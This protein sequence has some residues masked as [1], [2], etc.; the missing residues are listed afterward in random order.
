MI[1]LRK[2]TENK[3]F[4]YCVKP[5]DDVG[6]VLKKSKNLKTYVR[7]P[8]LF[9]N[10]DLTVRQL[11]LKRKIITDFHDRKAKGENI[12]LK[13]SNGMPQIVVAKNL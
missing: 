5:E 4:E 6:L 2:H 9:V 12:Y 10:K 13:Y 8:K 7:N 3:T 1:R 11:G